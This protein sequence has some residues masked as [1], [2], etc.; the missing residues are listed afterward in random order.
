MGRRRKCRRK[1]VLGILGFSWTAA[2]TAGAAEIPS[3]YRSLYDLLDRQ[4]AVVERH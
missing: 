1:I 4:L 2:A 3:A